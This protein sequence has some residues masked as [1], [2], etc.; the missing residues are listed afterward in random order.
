MAGPE[1]KEWSGTVWAA[2]DNLYCKRGVM[3]PNAGVTLK[4]ITDGTK[5]TIMLGELRAGPTDRDARGVWALGL[6][7]SSMLAMYGGGGD[8]NGPNACDANS[9]DVFSDIC[10]STGLCGPHDNPIGLTECMSCNDANASHQATARSR[11][12]GGV[13]VAMCDA[14]VQFISDNVETSGCWGGCCSVWDWMITSGDNGQGGSFNGQTR[15][16]FCR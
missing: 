9:D 15:G 4:Q 3:G 11:H 14:S 8:A 5:H 1:T 10:E 12:P 2:G 7:G 16:N 13:H 6:A